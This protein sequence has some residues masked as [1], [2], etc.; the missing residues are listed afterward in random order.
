MVHLLSIGQPAAVVQMKPRPAGGP[1]GELPRK[2]DHVG[3]YPI[4]L[5]T[6]AAKAWSR[7]A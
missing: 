5:I 2:P 4:C 7:S 3:F 6:S 1:G